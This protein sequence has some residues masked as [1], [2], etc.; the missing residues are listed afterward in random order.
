MSKAL[1]VCYGYLGDHL[2]AGS[3]AKKLKEEKQFDEVD[4]VVGFPQVIPL[5]ELNPHIDKVIFNGQIGPSPVATPQMYPDYD[6]I[7]QLGQLSFEIPPCVE[8]Q[9]IAGVQHPTPDFTVYTD[10]VVD[11]QMK[12]QF[13]SV[14][15]LGLPVLAIMDSWQ[16]K[17]FGFTREEYAAGVNVP[18]LGYGGRLRDIPKIVAALQERYVT[19]IVGA[20]PHVNQF[21]T[22]KGNVNRTLLEEASV[23]K[24]CDYFIGAEGGLANLASGVGCKTILTSDFVHQLYGWNGVIRKIPEPQLG[25]RYYF[26]SGHIDL[27]PYLTDDEVIASF[28]T[29]IEP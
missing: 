29:I 17:A 4:Y 8:V 13:A 7:V 9:Q 20:P 2:F 23:L 1:I 11:E 16:P 5:L 12:E 24:H 14:T 27:D 18:Y 10:P 28:I 22:A 3:I 15:A 21:E 26:P 25:P 6:R 19:I